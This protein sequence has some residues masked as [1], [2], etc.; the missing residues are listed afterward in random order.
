MTF[1]IRMQRVKDNMKEK[2][3]VIFDL[4]RNIGNC[5]EG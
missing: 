4:F 5:R 1:V 2:A 3:N